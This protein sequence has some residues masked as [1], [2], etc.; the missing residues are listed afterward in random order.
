PRRWW[1][2]RGCGASGPI[3][4]PPAARLRRRG[5]RSRVRRRA[6]RAPAVSE[7][8]LALS[9]F[10]AAHDMHGTAR[11]SMTILFEGRKPNALP[12][13]PQIE[14]TG[15]GWR[16]ELTDRL[17]PPLHAGSPGPGP[18]GARRPGTPA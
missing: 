15:S 16:A 7:P 14:A 2:M 11:S 4:P 9:F 8:A 10:D 12:Q 13:G 6:A 3:W 17:P 5:H 1:V 18:R